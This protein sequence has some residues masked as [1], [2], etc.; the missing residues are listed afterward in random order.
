MV[1]DLR[2]HRPDETVRNGTMHESQV[3]SHHRRP[4]IQGFRAIAVG[5]VVARHVTGYPKGGFVGVDVFFVLSGYLIIGLLVREH[6][7]RRR[8]SIAHFY[9][10]RIRR[11]IPL[12]F[13]VLSATDIAATIA[14]VATRAHQTVTDSVWAALFGANIHFARIGTDYFD[15][16][17]PESPVQHFWS[18]A[19]EEQFYLVCP[20]VLIV[21]LGICH[22]RGLSGRAVLG[23]VLGAV[24]VTS[25]VWCI[26]STS[27]SATKAYFSTPA[28]AWE[29][30]LGGL[31]AILAPNVQQL[32]RN[33]RRSMGW[34]G[35]ALVAY[36]VAEVG[37]ASFPGA[38]AALPVVGTL[39]MVASGEGTAARWGIGSR[40]L[41]ASVPLVYLGDIS[42]SFYLWHWPVLVI[43]KALVGDSGVHQALFVLIGV[44]AAVVSYQFVERPI[45]DSRWL[46]FGGSH[47]G[48]PRVPS[49]ADGGILAIGTGAVIVALVASAVA[50][51]GAGGTRTPV[52]TEVAQHAA[53]TATVAPAH[54][55]QAALTRKIDAS[56][57]AKSWKHLAPPLDQVADAGAPEWFKDRCVVVTAANLSHCVYG[58]KD[59]THHAVLLGDSF[60]IS[61]LPGIR[62][63]LPPDWNIQVLV[64]EECL[65]ADVSIELPGL[66]QD[67]CQSAHEF[68]S[69]EVAKIKPDLVIMSDAA[70]LFPH[71]RG[72]H[73]ATDR[74]S[75]VTTG[76]LTT[77]E[78]VAPNSHRIVFLAGPPSSGSLEQCVTRFSSPSACTEDVNRSWT[79]LSGAEK[80]AIADVSKA[81]YVDT[82]DWFCAH[83]ACPAVIG[84][85]PVSIDGR[86]LTQAYSQQL[87][88][89]IRQALR[90]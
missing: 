76:L 7:R 9:A 50:Y 33:L 20:A 5:V 40:W 27:V 25:Y 4:D 38:V 23:T 34:L 59:A 12:A 3:E 54:S 75:A 18:L 67:E 43:G 53:S 21:I 29:L 62:E 88:P 85:T 66:T 84:T 2:I 10:R 15:L 48:S 83:D 78:T 49:R 13:L 17:R 89:L 65:N 70:P 46:Q 56:L 60:A 19:V 86:H 52:I 77:L 68:A 45:L 22:R 57:A 69:A 64:H 63:A 35:L 61:Y 74:E 37:T 30:A 36:S 31:L 90:L 39:L 42:Y 58:P 6:E 79:D 32:N 11:I 71:I 1:T 14:F 44:A 87:A 28:R 51:H 55:V 41:V 81:R 72:T 47:N 26:H 16:T 8:I 73:D 80:S 24:A 82:R